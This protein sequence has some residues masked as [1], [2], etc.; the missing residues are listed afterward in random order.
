M[1]GDAVSWGIINPTSGGIPWLLAYS[2]AR[3]PSRTWPANQMFEDVPSGSTF[4]IWIQR[5]AGAGYINGYTC[6]VPPAGT[7][8]PP[9]NLPYFLPYN[10][11]TRGQTAKIVSNTF[12]PNCQPRPGSPATAPPPPTPVSPLPPAVQTTLPQPVPT[13]PPNQQPPP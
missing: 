6:G 9:G 10:N 5:L 4:Y 2:L 11:A 3:L 1:N 12:F 13:G 7:C 8:V